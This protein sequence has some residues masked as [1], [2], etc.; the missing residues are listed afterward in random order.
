[1]IDNF[2]KIR[3]LLNFSN[4]EDDF[5]FLQI[6][7]RKK[8]FTGTS[9]INGSNNNSRLV[10]AYYIKSLEHFDFIKPEVIKLCEVFEARAGINLNKR[11]FERTAYHHLKKV[12]DQILNKAFNKA[13]KAYS[14]AAG[15]YLSNEDKIWILDIDDMFDI[16]K[17]T[18]DMIS[19]IDRECQPYSSNKY[20]TII[21]SKNG[22]HILTKPFD[23][24]NF[25]ER[26]PKIDIHKN[27]PTNLYIP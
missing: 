2:D 1:M 15:D 21:P 11:S 4:S 26:Y 20:I 16:D 23:V 18:S 22:Y 24:K 6:L 13:Y 27:N 9:K 25:K 10:K 14:S 5:Y 12:T 17:R 3:K 7:Q 8:D 19:F